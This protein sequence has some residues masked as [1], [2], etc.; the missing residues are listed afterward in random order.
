MIVSLVP[1]Q[2]DKYAEF[3]LS[4]GRMVSMYRP[5][6]GH[7]CDIDDFNCSMNLAVIISRTVTIDEELQPMETYL[8]M[9]M[10]DYNEIIK[11]FDFA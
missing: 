4:D 6:F 8:R 11:R 7:V 9:Y 1:V 5:R 3:F 2:S 10:K